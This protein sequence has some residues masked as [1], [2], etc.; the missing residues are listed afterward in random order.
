MDSSRPRLAGML[1]GLAARCPNCGKG[2]LFRAYLKPVDSCE[3]CAHELGR[4]RADDGPAYFTILII[5]HLVVAPLLLFPWI[6]QASPWLTI[7][8]AVI[9]LTALTLFLLPRIKG[10]FIGL[11]W[12]HR[13]HG[14]E[15][16]PRSELGASEPQP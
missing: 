11:L 9:P 4:Y 7:P 10:A 1:R 13:A 8:A 16:G 2:K 6:W 3:V 15:H 12:S 5:G 14:D